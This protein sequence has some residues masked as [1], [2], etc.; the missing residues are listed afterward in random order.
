MKT[1]TLIRL[2]ST[3]QGT[4]GIL[5]VDD[6][7][8]ITGELPEKNNHQMFSCIPRGDY[9]VRWTFSNRF[10]RFTYEVQNVPERTGI[11]IHPAN[12]VG[13][14]E[15]G[16][17]CEV[18]GCI[19]LGKRTGTIEKQKTLSGSRLAVSDFEAYF[20]KEPFNLTIKDKDENKIT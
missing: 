4:F 7:Q 13:D 19:A 1:A 6:K 8:W 17:R 2:E 20:A 18:Q 10:K 5:T 15:L 16:Y 9:V 12:F 3:S 11:R 14:T